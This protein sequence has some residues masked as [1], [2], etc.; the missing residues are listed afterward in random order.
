MANNPKIIIE[1]KKLIKAVRTFKKAGKKVVFTNGC[2][3]LL[4]VG[5]VRFLK[6]A[7]KMGD[8][9]VLALNSDASVHRI[10]GPKRPVTP[11]ME[12]AEVMSALSCVDIVT[13]FREDDPYNI[14]KDLVPDVLVK[15]GDWALDKIIGADIVKAAGGKVKNVPYIKGRSTTNIIE[16]VLKYYK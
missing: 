8:V 7:K 1:R 6:A 4:H 14:I 2:Y 16:K 11:E 15:G 12:R 5:H 13:V 3:D 9:L 10:K